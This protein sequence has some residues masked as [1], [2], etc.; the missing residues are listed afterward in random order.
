MSEGATWSI[1]RPVPG[2]SRF[3]AT[4][5]SLAFKGVCSTTS[6]RASSRSWDIAQWRLPERESPTIRPPYAPFFSSGSNTSRWVHNEVALL[7]QNRA[8]NDRQIVLGPP[9]GSSSTPSRSSLCPLSN[10]LTGFSL[11][12]ILSGLRSAVNSY[13]KAVPALKG[14]P[15]KVAE[16]SR[17]E[18]PQGG[19]CP[20]GPAPQSG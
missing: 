18:G 5:S 8:L 2:R 7:V 6:C 14:Q 19:P 1:P 3:W 12:G 17:N 15:L 13:H 11:A 20:E 4:G 10:L 9:E 16:P